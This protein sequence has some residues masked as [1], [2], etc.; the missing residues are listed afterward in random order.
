[1]VML[2]DPDVRQWMPAGPVDDEAAALAWLRRGADWSSG[3]FAVWS[4]VDAQGRFSG[5]CMVVRID[6]DQRTAMVAYRTAPW[7]RG[8][9]LATAAV[10]A[11]THWAFGPVGLERLELVHAVANPA[12]CRVADKAGFVFEGTLAGGYRDDAG[13][14]WDSHLHALLRG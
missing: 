5:N 8:K 13:T 12:S 11:M 2:A 10:A 6:A 3:E 7:A 9:G 4:I 1:M 14:R